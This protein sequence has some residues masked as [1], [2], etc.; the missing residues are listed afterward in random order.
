M[1]EEYQAI[2]EAGFLLQIDSPDLA[3][4]LNVQYPDKSLEEYRESLASAWRR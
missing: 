3:M 1:K 4:G 2:V